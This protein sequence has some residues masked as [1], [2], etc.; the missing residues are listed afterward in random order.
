LAARGGL[1]R[2]T[3][4]GVLSAPPNAR[5]RPFEIILE[6]PKLRASYLKECAFVAALTAILTEYRK[7]IAYAQNI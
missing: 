2:E 7:I 5:P 6:T 4:A 3:P 1:V